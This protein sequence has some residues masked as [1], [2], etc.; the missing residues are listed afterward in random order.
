MSALVEA[1]AAHVRERMI[2]DS[3][4][5]WFHVQR[6]WANAR[7]IGEHEDVDQEIV[8]LAVLLHDLADWK[9]HDGDL[10]AGPRAAREWL[11]S[12]QADAKLVETVTEIVGAIS[13]KGA[14]VADAMRTLEGKVAQDADRLDALGAIGIART[15]AYAGHKGHPLHDPQAVPTLH[16]SAEA[17]HSEENTALNHFHEKLYLLKDRM[18]TATARRIAEERHAYME[19]FERQF[20]A[21]WDGRA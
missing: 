17:Y 5:D 20:L 9:F 12:Q 8:D 1:T 19:A 10:T 18:H 3:G 11:E 15:F 16:E 4:H 6:V 2:G 14:G 7:A 13:Y 21:E